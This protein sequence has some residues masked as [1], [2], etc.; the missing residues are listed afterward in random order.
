MMAPPDAPLAFPAFL[1]GALR[2]LAREDPSHY[3]RLAALGGGDGMRLR[4][5]GGGLVLR[6][7]ARSH[8]FEAEPAPAAVDVRADRATLLALFDG[9]LSLLEAIA[10]DRLR[11][12]G[13]VEAVLRFEQALVA[14]LDGVT[15]TSAFTPLLAAFRA[16]G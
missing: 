11:I 9:R 8:V 4:V 5:D 6:F 1:E 16:D 3:A 12:D 7:G 2:A 10:S 13:A 15:R 14:F